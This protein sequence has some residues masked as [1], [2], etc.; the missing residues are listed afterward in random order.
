MFRQ[1]KSVI[2]WSLIYKFRK[3]FTVVVLLLSMVLLSQ[4]LYADVVEY[5]QLTKKSEYLSYILPIK[6]IVIFTNITISAYLILTIFKKD[7]IK[8]KES[9]KA[10]EP[11][12]EKIKKTPKE[13]T[14][15]KET[16]SEREKSFL[17]KRL[18]SEAEVLMDR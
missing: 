4:W 2:I 5:L 16:L 6:W 8:E 10:K 14:Q 3:R 11:I 17:N 9:K 15:T 7:E 12:V 1:V 18:R 13:S